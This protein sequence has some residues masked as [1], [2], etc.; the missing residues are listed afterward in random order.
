MWPK[1][2][3]TRLYNFFY[4]IFRSENPLSW[5]ELPSCKRNKF[6]LHGSSRLSPKRL[7][8]TQINPTQDDSTGSVL[9][10]QQSFRQ[11][12]CVGHSQTRTVNNI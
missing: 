10:M 8:V 5:T 3:T 1:F 4:I 6:A 9:V 11:L 12:L 2:P 7:T